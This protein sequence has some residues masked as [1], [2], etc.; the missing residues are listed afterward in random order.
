MPRGAHIAAGGLYT[1]AWAQAA[2]RR[3]LRLWL[4]LLS[5][6]PDP[7][8]RESLIPPL[9]VA[10]VWMLHRALDIHVSCE[11]AAGGFAMPHPC[12]TSVSLCVT[13][14]RPD[15]GREV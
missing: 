12:E 15:H 4:P 11:G 7:A 13:S 8:E 6:H 2:V 10:L 14:P 9:D 3:Y 1:G 5:H